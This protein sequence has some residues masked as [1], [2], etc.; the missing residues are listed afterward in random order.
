M[1]SSKFNYSLGCSCCQ[2]ND[3]ERA[4]A[5]QAEDAAHDVDHDQYDVGEQ[6]GNWV[7]EVVATCCRG[8][9]IPPLIIE[10][11]HP[12]A[13][14]N[15]PDKQE[16]GDE[17]F[18]AASG[19]VCIVCL[20]AFFFIPAGFLLEETLHNVD[21]GLQQTHTAKHDQPD[22]DDASSSAITKKH[23]PCTIHTHAERQEVGH[24]TK[25]MEHKIDLQFQFPT[26]MFQVHVIPV[27]TPLMV[28][29]V[30]TLLVRMMCH[31]TFSSWTSLV[32]SECIHHLVTT[33]NLIP[34]LLVRG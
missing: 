9:A 29:V 33:A 19:P 2:S 1:S 5:A 3:K 34:R 11:K 6:V 26:R 32:D 10:S 4:A 16:N 30:Q 12:V 27:A 22:W 23:R 31:L 7:A 21:G 14:E 18:K 25:V 17:T 24:R 8:T 28:P 15:D 20:I 13:A